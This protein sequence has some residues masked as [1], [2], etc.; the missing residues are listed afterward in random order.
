MTSPRIKS[1]DLTRFAVEVLLGAGVSAPDAELVADSLVRADL[2]GH[3]SH[4]M[5][6]RRRWG[7]PSAPNCR[8]CAGAPGNSKQNWRSWLT[9]LGCGLDGMSSC[10]RWIRARVTRRA[11][12]TPVAIYL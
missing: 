6:M 5:S 9:T 10:P 8:N 7:C 12:V 4:G 1:E 3:Q 11:G 2:W